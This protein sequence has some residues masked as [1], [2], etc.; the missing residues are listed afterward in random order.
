M[1]IFF[2]RPAQIHWKHE[3]KRVGTP[4]GLLNLA[5]AVRAD[6]DV[7]F[8]DVC[9]EGY[10]YEE[11]VAPNVFRFGLNRAQIA[12]RIRQYNPDLI[13]ISNSF[14]SYWKQAQEIAEIAKQVN[15]EIITV[16]G[17]QHASGT[18]EETLTLDTSKA[19]DYVVLGEGDGIFGDL[20]QRIEKKIPSISDIDG[21]VSRQGDN[22]TKRNGNRKWVNLEMS[23]PP[24]FDLL[25]P[26]FYTSQMSHFGQPKGDNFINVTFS[27]GCPNMCSYCTTSGH[28]GTEVRHC[29]EEPAQETVKNI[30][31]NG[32]KEIVVED[33]NF[34]LL[35][36]T[37]QK[38]IARALGKSGLP[39]NIDAG[40]YYP[41][42]NQQFASLLSDNGCYRVFLPI[43]SPD[44]K[45]MHSNHKYLELNN[46]VDCYRHL[47]KACS[48]LSSH[49]IEFYF[50]IM[51]GFPG[52]NR[53]DIIESCRFAEKVVSNFGGIGLSLHWTHPY[54]G[55]EFY[56]K[57]YNQCSAQ[58][59]WQVAPE[60]YTFVKPVFALPGITLEEMEEV[61]INTLKKV[62]KTT[63]IN[64]SEFIGCKSDA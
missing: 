51:L 34:T 22:I 43:E 7:A 54:P 12:S 39:W 16:M 23:T 47:E 6:H 20:V 40:L 10:D 60:Y 41:S 50:A 32:W 31:K 61:A 14:T 15:P 21:I 57:H 62:N 55:T 25:N 52:Q 30:V 63:V 35:P 56:N 3:A 27:R 64:A 49:N 45:L 26:I 5:A 33:D 28:F 44:I 4:L 17:G 11:E 1:K 9:A 48:L 53:Q 13:A 24:A 46:S 38:F 18:A 36:F 58:R 59:K 2:I 8:L 37:F 42:I 19:I 29:G